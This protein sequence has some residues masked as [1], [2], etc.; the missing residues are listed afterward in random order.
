MTKSRTFTDIETAA[1]DAVHYFA[2]QLGGGA[3]FAD[4]FDLNRRTAYR[5][6]GKQQPPPVGIAQQL[7]DYADAAERTPRYP[8][9]WRDHALALRAFIAQRRTPKGGAHG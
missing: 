5:L 1:M 7:L 4:R 9:V 8:L 6:V 3:A 2:S